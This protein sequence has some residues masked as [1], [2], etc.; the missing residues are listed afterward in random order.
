MWEQSEW[1]GGALGKRSL[2]PLKNAGHSEP[3]QGLIHLLSLLETF[4][5]LLGRLA[6]STRSAE[7]GS[8]SLAGSLPH[9]NVSC[10]QTF[11][12]RLESAL[13]FVDL[14]TWDST[15]IRTGER[16]R[17]SQIS[18][19]CSLFFFCSHYKNLKFANMWEINGAFVCFVTPMYNI[20]LF[21]SNCKKEKSEPPD[22]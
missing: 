16:M 1:Q 15:Q 8:S 13:T 6:C 3:H 19:L 7:D 11:Q 14:L 21:K 20:L 18:T 22:Q 4:C 2:S 10:Q 17:N 12:G 5:P 9:C